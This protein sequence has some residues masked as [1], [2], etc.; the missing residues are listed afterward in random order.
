MY[1]YRLSRLTLSRDSHIVF[2]ICMKLRSTT[3]ERSAVPLR[4]NQ[5]SLT[6]RLLMSIYGA[7]ILDVSRSHTTTQHSR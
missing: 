6:L 4:S 2:I 5:V 1:D 7:P 3:I